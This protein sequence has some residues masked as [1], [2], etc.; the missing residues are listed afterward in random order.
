MDANGVACAV[1]CQDGLATMGCGPREVR[2][3]VL[4]DPATSAATAQDA[5]RFRNV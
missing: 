5:A 2:F 4:C 3:Q 1:G